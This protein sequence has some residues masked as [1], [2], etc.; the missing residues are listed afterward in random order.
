MPL[1]LPGQP[2]HEG[3]RGVVAAPVGGPPLAEY[4]SVDLQC[5]SEGKIET[6]KTNASKEARFTQPIASLKRLISFYYLHGSLRRVCQ[7]F[8][9]TFFGGRRQSSRRGCRNARWHCSRPAIVKNG[10]G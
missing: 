5:E 2:L 7:S 1:E 10:D 6:S 4:V 8:Q 9:A 3:P